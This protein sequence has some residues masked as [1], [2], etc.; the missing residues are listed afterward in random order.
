MTYNLSEVARPLL[1]PEVVHRVSDI[2]DDPTIVPK[3][4]GLYGWW[5]DDALPS[6]PRLETL[7]RDGR[8]LLYVG[9]APNGA[10][11][12]TGKR[13][14]RDR[15]KNH[16]RGPVASSTVRLTLLT[17]IG[18]ELSISCWRSP[19]GKVIIS[20]GDEKRLTEWMNAHM[21]VAWMPHP[22]PWL[23]ETELLHSGLRLPLNISG[24]NGEFV[25][26]LKSSRSRL[27]RQGAVLV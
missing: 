25:T 24:S 10:K 27:G 8:C 11:G 26:S 9:I 12:T 2:I 22:T 18:E 23:V 15:L 7:R 5:F 21:R 14:L 6:V 1:D 13:T 17:I 19:K 4:G 3:L 16:C 20:K